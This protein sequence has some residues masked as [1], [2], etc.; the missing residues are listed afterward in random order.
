MTD[1]P[2]N[3]TAALAYARAQWQHLDPPAKYGSTWHNDCQAFA[4]VCYGLLTGGFATA[5]AQ[6]LGLD[7]E[8]RHPTTDTSKAPV[9]AL[10]FSRGANPAGHVW[11]AAWP[12]PNDTPGSWSPDFNAEV[13]GG[14]SKVPRNAPRDRWGHTILGWG[15]SI[16]GYRLDLTG[17]G[18]AKAIESKHY[19]RIAR[20]INN[21]ENALAVAQRNHDIHDVR[22][23]ETE[24]RHQK[25]L[26]SELRR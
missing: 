18:V 1:T 21:L 13:Y 11:L 2:N 12:F 16:N 10:M 20:A 3:R 9:G 22:L 19:K 5:Y 15:T 8:D 4:H 24:V 26:Y 25:A 14:I 17:N 23:I 6:W 7:P